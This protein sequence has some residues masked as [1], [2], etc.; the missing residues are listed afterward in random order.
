MH[1]TFRHTLRA[2]FVGYVVQA[3]VNNFVPLLFLTFEAAYRIPLSQITWLVTL[4]FGVQLA[5]DLVSAKW[6]DKIG[7]RAAALLAHLFAA[8]GLIGLTVL[9]ALLPTPF[10]GLSVAMLIYALGG[11]LLEVLVS[12]MVEACPTEHK[13]STMSLLH[14]FY[15]WGHVAVVLL[16]TAF[17]ALFGTQNWKYIALFWA[18]I[19]IL[20]GLLFLKVPIAPLLK[21]GDR[22]MSLGGLL[23][24]RA[25]WILF[26]L[27]ICAGACEQSVSQWA[28]TL[29]E[30]G[31]HVQKTVGD[32]AGPL[33]FAAA[34]GLSRTVY[35]KFGA[36]LPLR[37]CMVGSGALCFLSYLMIALSPWPALGFAG[38]ALCGLSVGLLWPGTFS[39]ASA[40]IPK[41]GTMLFAFLALGGDLGCTGGPTLVGVFSG[42]F[43]GDLQR[44][45]LCAALFP[46]LLIIGLAALTKRAPGRSA[47]SKGA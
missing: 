39:L 46:I 9:P 34:M 28:S 1:F 41:G 24:C 11:G 35:G 44:G 47:A 8:L 5:V 29:A 40:G 33:S 21:A 16:S 13:E 3:I 36:K 22:G 45:I 15:C 37:R 17:F 14:A 19:P 32:L 43:G 18:L 2:C 25:F 6:I 30:R 12:P 31:L 23:R 42:A 38:C 27:M 10:L 26:L 7:Y 4:N 20:N